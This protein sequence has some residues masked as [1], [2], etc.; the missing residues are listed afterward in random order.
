MDDLSVCLFWLGFCCCCCCVCKV[1]HLVNWL[2]MLH[3]R[4]A[5]GRT[6]GSQ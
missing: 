1:W 6:I 4:G 2:W 3:S 5:A